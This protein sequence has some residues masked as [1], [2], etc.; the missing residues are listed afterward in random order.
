MSRFKKVGAFLSLVG[1]AL[2]MPTLAVAQ[3]ELKLGHVLTADSH[4]QAAATAFAEAVK[5]KTNGKVTIKSF[6]QGQ[7]GGEVQEVQA[8]RLGT[9]DALVTSQA[10]VVNTIKEWQIFDVP[11]LFDSV[12]QANKALQSDTGRKLLD[13]VDRQGMVGLAWFSVLE[14]DV[15][16]A[17]KPVTKL[18][19]L[20]GFKIRVIQ[21]PGFVKAYK[22]LGANPVPLPYS[23]LYLALQQGVVDGA[24]SSPELMI[25]DK[26][27]EVSKQFVLSHVNHMPV[28][29]LMSKSVFAK[30]DAETQ[31]AIRAAAAEATAVHVASYRKQ[32]DQA[33]AELKTRG[34]EVSTPTDLKA[35]QAAT[36]V[37]AKEIVADTPDGATWLAGL[38]STKQ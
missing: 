31:A 29:L 9:Q 36:D 19:D 32:Y 2:I 21:S 25:Q 16:S 11:Y 5:A 37:A 14:R 12:G 22:A 10:A 18:S 23:Q 24:E 30:L 6:P 28:A 4:Y 38:R 34:I 13:L 17:K 3:V 1:T 20:E 35:W 33:L 15:V 7:L 26:F 27:A 8:L